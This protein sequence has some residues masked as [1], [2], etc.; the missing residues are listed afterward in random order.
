MRN[1]TENCVRDSR[2]NMSPFPFCLIVL[3]SMISCTLS[4]CG[5]YDPSLGNITSP[6]V[7]LGIC[8][9]WG[10]PPSLDKSQKYECDED[11]RLYQK[12][13]DGYN[14]N[15]FVL[16]SRIDSGEYD[17]NKGQCYGNV[18]LETYSRCY[19]FS[20]GQT[21]QCKCLSSEVKIMNTNVCIATSTGS[22][23]V[24]CNADVVTYKYYLDTD[25]QIPDE[26]KFLPKGCVEE[27]GAQYV[28]HLSIML[29]RCCRKKYT[30]YAL[31]CVFYNLSNV[32]EH[33]SP[34]TMT[35]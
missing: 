14:C 10:A 8:G 24:L 19:D 5:W 30:T 6:I 27:D 22:Y 28:I 12:V 18:V 21:N 9:N 2:C 11:G 1:F 17:C 23:I 29:S 26:V 33:C 34:E 7:P 3:L 32:S 35:L 4:K 16:E 13:Y 15:D 25:C 31:H 20:L